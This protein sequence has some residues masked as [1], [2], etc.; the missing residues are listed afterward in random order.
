M[1][2]LTYKSIFSEDGKKVAGTR[3]T[4]LIFGAVD[5][6]SFIT[7]LSFKDWA[8]SPLPDNSSAYIKNEV[9]NNLLKQ[10]TQ[11][12]KKVEYNGWVRKNE[13]ATFEQKVNKLLEYGCKIPKSGLK[14]A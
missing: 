9:L 7:T 4:K 14:I 3:Q 12:N 11:F 8:N 5:H 6:D 1:S 10:I 2:T 13:Y